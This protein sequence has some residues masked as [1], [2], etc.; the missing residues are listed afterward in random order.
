MEERI[1]TLASR[2]LSL[3]QQSDLRQLIKTWER[4]NPGA[5]EVTNVRLRNLNGVHLSAF[6]DGLAAQGIMASARKLLGRVDASLLYGER[7]MFLIEHTPGIL[8]QQTDLTLAQIGAAFP[9]A[10]V[11]PDTLAN[12]IKDLPAMLQ[13]GIDHNQE[14]INGL[15]PK[16]AATLETANSL[17][18]NLNKTM[19]TVQNLTENNRNSAL[20]Q[21]DPLALLKETNRT[22]DHLDSSINSLSQLLEK[23]TAGGGSFADLPLVIHEQSERLMDAALR[24]IIILIGT[25]FG[26]A[27]LLLVLAKLLFRRRASNH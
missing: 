19:L 15:L 21:T 6:D 24:R 3:K 7:V 14:A 13:E 16:I 4:Q 25:F 18:S 17:S 2:S 5:H 1:W 26:G 27:A 23:T 8:A 12:A 9:I 20:L 11:R 10:T 22:L